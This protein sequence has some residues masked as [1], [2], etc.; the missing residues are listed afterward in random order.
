MKSVVETLK[1]KE[2]RGSTESLEDYKKRKREMWGE[3]GE[4]KENIFKKSNRVLRSPIRREDME[5]DL[6]GMLKEW[7]E[8]MKRR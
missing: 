5:G 4:R 8:E 2:T 7:K 3:D 6:V 1:S